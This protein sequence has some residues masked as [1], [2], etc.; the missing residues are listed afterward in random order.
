MNLLFVLTPK[1]DVAYLYQDYTLRQALEKMEHHRY[2][3]LPIL[4]RK[5][6]YV[7]TIT[8]GDLL[9]YIKDHSNLD[10]QLAEEIPLR[11]VPRYRDNKPVRIDVEMDELIEMAAVQNFVPVI[12]G[13]DSFIG[14]VTRRSLMNYGRR[15]KEQKEKTE[16]INEKE[17]P[18]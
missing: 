8:E 16:H 5:G 12:D 11:A 17:A 10:L 14:I 7:G 2:G 18:C 4:N 15:Q 3:A 9:W 6:E 13:K 1:L